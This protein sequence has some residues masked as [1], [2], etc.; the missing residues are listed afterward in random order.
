[1]STDADTAERA[2]SHFFRGLDAL[3]AG[4]AAAAENEFKAALAIVPDR[5]SALGNLAVALFQQDKLGEAIETAQRALAR[6]PNAT[7]ALV[8]MGSAYAKLGDIDAAVAAM[9]RATA[10]APNDPLALMGRASVLL[11]LKLFDQAVVAYEAARRIKPDLE[12]VSGLLVKAKIYNCDWSD[13]D[14][15]TDALL[16]GIRAGTASAEPF[17]LLAMNA[18]PAD[19]LRC[20][21]ATIEH[22]FRPQPALWRGELYTHDRIR[23]AYVS[24]DYRD[25]PLSR[26]MAGIFEHHDR[27]RFEVVA[28]ATNPDDGSP[29]RQRIVAAP[30]RFVDLGARSNGEIA[31]WLRAAEIDVAVDLSGLTD[32][33]RTRAFAM[34]PAPIQVSYLGFPGTS[35][36]PYLDYL[37]ADRFVIP[38]EQRPFYSEKIAALPDTY[39]P[40]DDRWPTTL[41]APSRAEMGLLENGFVFC[42]FNNSYKITPQIFDIWM[43][44]LKA[45]PGSVLWLLATSPAATANLLKEA[46]LRG[47]APERVVFAEH[48]T[49]ERYLA[50]QQLADLALD[51]LPYNAHTT[52]VDALW[53]GLPIVTCPGETFPSRVAASLLNA[54][55][56]PELVTTSLRDY[57]ALALTLARDPARLAAIRRKVAANRTTTALFNTAQRTRHL[58]A[59]FSAMMERHRRGEEPADLAVAPVGSDERV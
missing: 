2:K 51:T 42:C 16:S 56:L 43:R 18:T 27:S 14:R 3:D 17:S 6:D 29:E 1:M 19:Q 48:D 46:R 50:R 58:E 53:T 24:G 22:D 44:L 47:V 21:T 54:M 34:R 37:L 57:E 32:K 9:D 45:V 4:D 8:T 38:A 20:A 25:H 10:R 5:V 33:G 35:G 55:A 49:F 30:E 36:A 7:G 39:Y 28:V 23:I 12:S 15:E 41:Q 31:Q 13:L 11:K 26:L 52:A 59:A 40:T